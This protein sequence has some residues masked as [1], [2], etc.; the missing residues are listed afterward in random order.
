[1][2]PRTVVQL[3]GGLGNQLFQ[4]AAGREIAERTNTPL[5]IDASFVKTEEHRD[6]ALGRYGITDELVINELDAKAMLDDVE[7][8]TLYAREQFGAWTIWEQ[9]ADFHDQLSHAPAGSYIVGYWQA[10]RYFAGVAELLRREH[11]AMELRESLRPLAQELS[12]DPSSVAVH[13]RRG[14]YV[15]NPTITELLPPKDAAY[16]Y[17]AAEQLADAVVAP[18]FYVFSDDPEWCRDELIL[19]GTSQIV[20]GDNT[21]S[22]DLA[23][24]AR[25]SHAVIANSTFGWWGAWLGESPGSVIVG[26]DKWFGIPR[27]AEVDLLPARWLRAS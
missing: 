16:Y 7:A 21:E 26:P 6:Y 4:Y 8:T 18:K 24:I 27:L 3:R 15:T 2:N 9:R 10:E 12:A 13:V 17:G 20:S 11:A 19:P 14:D 25:C 23:L 5:V 22:E 1:M